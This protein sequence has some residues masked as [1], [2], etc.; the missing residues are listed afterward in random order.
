MN[1]APDACGC[2]LL[3]RPFPELDRLTGPAKEVAEF[4]WCEL[5]RSV[6][7][8]HDPTRYLTLT[9]SFD[10]NLSTRVVVRSHV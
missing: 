2:D 1:A 6:V 4:S 8:N 3:N 10:T 7:L 5:Q 9:D